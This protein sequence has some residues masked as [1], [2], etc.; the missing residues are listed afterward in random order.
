VARRL[1]AVMLTSFGLGTSATVIGLWVS[2]HAAAAAG[3]TIA[4]V[5]VLQFFAILAARHLLT[6]V[7]IPVKGLS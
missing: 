2:W 4:A 1:P 7:L 5:A 3:A 6:G